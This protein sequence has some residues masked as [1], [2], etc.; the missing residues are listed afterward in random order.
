MID[1]VAAVVPI[2]PLLVPLEVDITPN[3]DGLPGITQLR[4]TRAR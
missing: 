4:T 1:L 3:D 2:L